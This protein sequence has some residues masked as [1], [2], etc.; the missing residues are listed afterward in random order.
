MLPLSLPADAQFHRA[1]PQTSRPAEHGK[2]AA[3]GGLGLERLHSL[4]YP[5][6]FKN[7]IK[8]QVFSLVLVQNLK[9]LHCDNPSAPR[10]PLK[11]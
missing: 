7:S 10:G 5:W 1:P 9:L 3:A 6:G 11:G 2:I 4:L 8:D